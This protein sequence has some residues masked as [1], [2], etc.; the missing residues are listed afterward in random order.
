M[1]RSDTPS[2]RWGAAARSGGIAGPSEVSRA[3]ACRVF[4]LFSTLAGAWVSLA[5]LGSEAL[6]VPIEAGGVADPET[7]WGGAGGVGVVVHNEAGAVDRL[8][9]VEHLT[10]A[11]TRPGSTPIGRDGC[12]TWNRSVSGGRARV[13]PPWRLGGS[14]LPVPRGTSGA[15]TASVAGGR[16]GSETQEQRGGEPKPAAPLLLGPYWS[17]VPQS[18]LALMIVTGSTGVSALSSRISALEASLTRSRPSSTRP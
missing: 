3:L 11:G 17:S 15:S 1:V 7:K 9:H 2:I 13:L 8:F 6:L 10:G 18:I 4:H 12:S 14:C 5:R 16:V